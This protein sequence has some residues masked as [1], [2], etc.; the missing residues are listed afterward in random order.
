MAIVRFARQAM[1][2]G[3]AILMLAPLGAASG[4][5][6]TVQIYDAEVEDTIHL[7]AKPVLRAAGLPAGS[8]RVHLIRSDV[9][10]AFVSS[11]RHL[12]LT[13]ELLR[14][15]R[16][17]GQLIGV[18]AHELGH[19][20]GGHLSQLDAMLY[21]ARTPAM[22]TTI[23]AVAL[24]VLSGRSDVA[25]AGAVTGASLVDRRL[26][27]FSRAQEQAADRA[28]VSYLDRAGISSRGLLEILEHLDRRRALLLSREDA[29]A[30][31]YQTTHPPTFERVDF[32]RDHIRRSDFSDAPISPALAGLHER[33]VAKLDGFTAPP[34]RVL[35]KYPA[36]DARLAARYARAI[37]LYRKTEI[38]DAVDAAAALIAA[39]PDDAYFRELMGQIL[40][41]SGR[42]EAALPHYEKAVSLRPEAP[43][44]RVGLAHAQIES[45][46]DGLLPTAL[47]HLRIARRD[48]HGISL[49][50][51]LAAAAHGRLGEEGE[52]ALASAEY[53]LR[54]GA[55]EN[56]VRMAKRA[57]HL[58]KRDSPGWLRA[59]DLIAMHG[60][61]DDKDR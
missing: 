8:V 32:L 21:K 48:E 40:F 30:I 36:S 28:A 20:S 13:T 12:F 54:T 25:I 19:I 46:N 26:L 39:H 60:K 50:W 31:T 45:N 10:N 57:Q 56:A 16:H 14:T 37:A 1:S 44:L 24:G 58:L 33:L 5:S 4:A 52:A 53:A 9:P 15:T 34:D 22:L 47:K 2:L 35:R 7:Y 23:A 38:Q 61:S 49:A 51:R 11:G 42:I 59:E 41:E 3:T 55:P 27:A 18:I 43:L 6:R 17:P 29:R